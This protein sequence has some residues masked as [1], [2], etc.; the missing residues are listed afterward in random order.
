MSKTIDRKKLSESEWEIMNVLW[1]KGPCALG[2]VY[3]GLDGD[4]NW[5][6]DTV[7]VLMHR[8][9]DKGWLDTKR[10]GNSYLYSPA[11]ERSTAVRQALHE[12]SRRVLDGMLS[13]V[14]AYLCEEQN[15]SEE[16]FN[17]LERLLDE[18]RSGKSKG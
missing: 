18:H 3:Q 12:F 6:Y 14:V 16:D 15:L 8:M 1:D 10:V 9:T 17:K 4:R 13:P 2:E 7:K 11:V 5:S